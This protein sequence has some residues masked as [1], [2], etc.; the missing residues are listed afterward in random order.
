MMR[1]A[2][3]A[4]PIERLASWDAWVAKLDAALAAA[5][6][7][8]AE[9]VVVPEYASMELG[10]L[11]ARESLAAMQP[12]LAAY[13]ATYASLAAAHS[14]AVVAGS[15]PEADGSRFINRARV[16]FAGSEHVV[17][18]QRM[19]RFEAEH[20]GVSPGSAAPIIDLGEFKLA[21]AL[22]YDAEFPV[23]VRSLVRAGATLIAVPSCTDALAGYHRV[24]ISCAARALE[25]QCYVIQAPTVG[26]APWSDSLDANRGAAGI[27]APPDRGFPPDGILSLGAL[28]APGLLFAD[29]DPS[30]ISQVR[31]DG[32]V[33]NHRDWP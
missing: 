11:L 32:Q 17:E 33:L 26:L 3:W 29:L 1:V 18:K 7:D 27:F 4:Y 9:L 28:D 5:A 2:A 15:F 12:F 10:S 25:N 31:L 16:F 20:W 30:A 8:G 21:V 24:R 6:A 22:C 14:L 23:L 13:R 19:T